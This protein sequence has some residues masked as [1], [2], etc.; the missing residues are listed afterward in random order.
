M[1]ITLEKV[2]LVKE[3]TGVS[4]GEAKEALVISDGDVLDAIIYLEQKMQAEKTEFTEANKGDEGCKTETIEELK[5]WLKDLINKG[6]VT[7][8]KVSKDGKKL[9]D[10]PVNAGIAAGV[11][12]IIIPPILA[13]VVVA[14]VVTQV[15]I[16]ITKA[17]GSVEIVNKY[18]SQAVN[19]VK[20]KASDVAD[21]VKEKVQD[22][23]EGIKTS[24]NT[25]KSDDNS[26]TTFTYTV[27]FSDEDDKK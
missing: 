25:K 4:Y 1:N 23:N 19:E 7:R 11:I 26:E 18:I 24:H 2:D 10:V 15:T 17:D 21:K 3:R 6:N 5:L 27:D 9:V 14:A 8:V 20:D 16:E 13:F 22:V 12:A